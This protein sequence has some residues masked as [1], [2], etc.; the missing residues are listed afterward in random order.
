MRGA[1]VDNVPELDKILKRAI[2]LQDI[3]GED[4]YNSRKYQRGGNGIGV[5]LEL[6]VHK[7]HAWSKDHHFPQFREVQFYK[8]DV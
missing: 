1:T 5:K 4:I 3:A 6:I 7:G 8:G 2:I